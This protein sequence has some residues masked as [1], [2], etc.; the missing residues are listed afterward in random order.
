MALKIKQSHPSIDQLCIE[1]AA[2][3]VFLGKILYYCNN[4]SS[5]SESNELAFRMEVEKVWLQLNWYS[6]RS[7]IQI[8][9]KSIECFHNWDGVNQPTS[10]LLDS[11]IVDV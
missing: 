1:F 11:L 2:I 7:G 5:N 9:R 8:S 3:P 6:V 4:N 10:A